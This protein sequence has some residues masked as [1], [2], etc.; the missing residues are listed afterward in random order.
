[1]EEFQGSQG[2]QGNQDSQGSQGSQ[3]SQAIQNVCLPITK[4]KELADQQPYHKYNGMWSRHMESVS[5]ILVFFAWLGLSGGEGIALCPEGNLLTYEQV[6][7][8]MGGFALS[9]MISDGSAN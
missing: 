6:A 2:S 1:M 4:I 3:G 5:F 9:P 7:G 8:S